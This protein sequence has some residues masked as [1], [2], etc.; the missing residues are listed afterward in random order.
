MQLQGEREEKPFSSPHTAYAH[1][2]LQSQP[3]LSGQADRFLKERQKVAFEELQMQ[4][5]G[6][7]QSY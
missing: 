4:E 3:V 2:V 6:K 7:L 1:L 5:M